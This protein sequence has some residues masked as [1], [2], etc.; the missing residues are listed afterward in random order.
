VV[1]ETSPTP[2]DGNTGPD[3]DLVIYTG[4]FGV[5]GG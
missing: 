1:P 4:D 3:E 2:P 5:G